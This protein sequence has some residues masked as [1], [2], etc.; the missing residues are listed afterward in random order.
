MA[1]FLSNLSDSEIE[2]MVLD[3]VIENYPENWHSSI[4]C[5]ILRCEY[6]RV[7][8]KPEIVKNYCITD[9]DGEPYTFILPV[10]EKIEYKGKADTDT[11]YLKIIKVNPKTLKQEKIGYVSLSDFSLDFTNLLLNEGYK[12]NKNL[13]A[14]DFPQ[15]VRKG[16]K[17]RFNTSK[18]EVGQSKKAQQL[19]VT[20]MKNNYNFGKE[21]KE[22]YKK[23]ET[24]T[25][26]IADYF[27][28]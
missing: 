23:Y 19:Y 10:I 6:I 12:K 22:E 16:D 4:F 14:S 3:A 17:L 18:E 5:E 11:I 9:K 13:I 26:V 24:K 15:L 2:K 25:N 20:F 1:K 8:E 28:K 7:R 27:K 21:Y